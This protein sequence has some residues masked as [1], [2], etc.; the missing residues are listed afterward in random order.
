MTQSEP[1][2]KPVKLLMV[3]LGCDKNLVDS[4]RMLGI[5]TARGFEITDDENEAEAAVINTCCFIE[6]ARKES[7]ERI[8]DLSRLKETA[9]L[10]V[11]IAAGCMAQ[12]YREEIL[13]EIPEIDAIVGTSAIDGIAVA[14]EQALRGKKEAVMRDISTD[15]DLDPLNRVVTTGGHY[16]Y[17]KI[18]EGCDKRC[19]YCSIPGFRGHYRSVPKEKLLLEAEKLAASG[20]KELILVAQETTLYGTDLYGRKCL[21][22]LLH[23]LCSIP[24]LVW[25]RILYCYPEEI[26]PELIDTIA[27]EPK[28]CRYLDLPIQ[29]ASD[30]ILKRM[31]RRTTE[32]DL[33]ELI[34]TLREK[35]PGIVLRTTMITGFPGETEEDYETCLS[36]V[37]EMRFDRLGVFMYSREEGTPAAAMKPQIPKKIKKMRE[38]GIMEAQQRISL[39]NNR[40]KIGSVMDVFV[41][42]SIPE[43]GVYVGRTAGD[44]PSVDGFMFFRSRRTLMSGDFVKVKVAA[45]SEYDLHGEEID[46]ENSQFDEFA[47]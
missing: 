27:S 13:E 19:T 10:K 14:V 29:H 35:I 30:R 36:F 24:G 9:K 1:V 47:E 6:D 31:A 23:G 42:G 4:E 37:R 17:L 41:E 16:A 32:S 11:L 2:T 34:R 20:V 38:A 25:I 3:S 5:L 39:E 44:A 22:E 15:P 7:I 46:D 40:A 21:H 43:D 45:A 18:A 8:F 28:I 33:K 26:Y 12:R